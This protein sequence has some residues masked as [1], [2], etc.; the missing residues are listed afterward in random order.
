MAY[1]PTRQLFQQETILRQAFLAQPPITALARRM[2][3]ALRG[4]SLTVEEF[5]QE[6]TALRRL[7]GGDEG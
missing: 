1:G 6:Y 2:Q 3:P 7:T 4:D 5:Y